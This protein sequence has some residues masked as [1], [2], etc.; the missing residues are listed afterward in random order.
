MCCNAKVY[1]TTPLS[2]AQ[3]CQTEVTKLLAFTAIFEAKNL[4]AAKMVTA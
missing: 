4:L 2:V 3:D 1:F